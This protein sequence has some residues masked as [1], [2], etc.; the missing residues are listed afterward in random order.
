M[1]HDS[2]FDFYSKRI[3]TC[4]SDGFINIYDANDNNKLS[5][6]KMYL[7]AVYL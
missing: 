6:I 3:A 7:L 2:K 4:A 5:S 1:I